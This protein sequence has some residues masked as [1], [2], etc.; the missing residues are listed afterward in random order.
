MTKYFKFAIIASFFGLWIDSFFKTNFQI[1][2]GFIL[3]FSFGILHGAND[4]LLIRSINQE[5]QTN[6]FYKILIYYILIV[7]VGALLFYFIPTIALISFIIVSGYHFG[8]QQWQNLDQLN[9]WFKFTFQFCYGTFILF[10][11]FYFHQTEVQTVVTEITTIPL[12]I[13]IITNGFKILSITLFIFF[14]YLYIKHIR[15]RNQLLL[16]IFYL[17]V[18]GIIFFSSSLIWGFAIF[19]IIW[20]SIPSMIDQIKFLYQEVTL[21]SFKLYFK[22]AFL[23]W[24]VSLFGIAI[25]YLLFNDEKIFNALFFSFLASITFPHVLVILKMFNKKL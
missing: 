16:E 1:Y 17:I 15:I 20:H 7:I 9:Q 6:Y 10:L 18:F 19:F 23:Y 22:S 5:K 12:N 11:L 2:L 13:A 25:L 4:L 3:I 14:L 24:I 21:K 8:E